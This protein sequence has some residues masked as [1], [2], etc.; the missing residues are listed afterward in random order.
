MAAGGGRAG[1]PVTPLHVVVAKQPRLQQQQ[2]QELEQ[3]QEQEQEQGHGHGQEQHLQQARPQVL[4]EVDAHIPCVQP[5]SNGS[6]RGSSSSDN[7][8][9]LA[10]RTP[11]PPPPA[12]P[13]I[14]LPPPSLNGQGTTR[15]SSIRLNDAGAAAGAQPSPGA[16]A[17][18]QRTDAAAAAGDVLL[19]AAPANRTIGAT[20]IG[21]SGSAEVAA[22]SES[23]GSVASA[24]VP[25]SP[26]AARAS[27]LPPP[28]P[29]LPDAG[30]RRLDVSNGTGRA[31]DV[32]GGSLDSLGSRRAHDR[33]QQPLPEAGMWQEIQEIM[34]LRPLKV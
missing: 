13:P 27:P 4:V 9:R 15:S 31:G 30:S 21:N 2:Q 34:H 1:V 3:E 20:S 14:L 25:N 7:C 19:G 17:N 28:S 11:P 26:V 8:H 22:A 29:R 33:E 16:D 23:A 12:P 5:N 18:V 24:E 6:G 10:I 32:G